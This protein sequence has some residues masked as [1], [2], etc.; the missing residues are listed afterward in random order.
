MNRI[1]CIDIGAT[2]IKAAILDAGA[3][4]ASDR[5]RV[6]TPKHAT[7]KM[8]L[9]ILK[10]I[11]RDLANADTSFDRV[12]VGFP[13]V[14]KDGSTQT[15]HNLGKGWRGFDLQSAIESTLGAKTRI[16]N[17][18]AVQ[19]L[20]ASEGKGLELTITLGTGVGSALFNQ[21]VLVPNLQLC[22]HCFRKDESYEEQLGKPALKRIGIRRWNERVHEMIEQLRP[23]F[24]FDQLYIG[25]GHSKHVRK[26]LP[27]DVHLI[28]NDS[29]ILGGTRLWYPRKTQTLHNVRIAA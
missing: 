1:L 11:S 18:A 23:V 5:L 10:D 14:V 20:W 17:D 4:P 9:R 25:G 16:V 19:G 26:R 8:V 21:G 15:A 27:S 3:K 7:P 12:S 24:N 13:G 22:H 29:G 28:D 2:A 6:L